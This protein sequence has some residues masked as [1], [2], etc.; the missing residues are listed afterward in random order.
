MIKLKRLLI[1]VK[2]KSFKDL[3]KTMPS[4]L[5]KRIYN[6][7]KIKQRKDYHPEGNVL[8]HTIYSVD[9]AL[10]TGD[11]DL[12]IAAMLHDIGK[13]KT[14]GIHPKKGHETHWGHEQV[15]AK[16]I[17]KYRNWIVDIGG[18]PSNVY[19]IVKNSGKIKS[20]H[21]MR[22][23]KQDKMKVQKGRFSKLS[24][25][26]KGIDVGGRSKK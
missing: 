24:K 4:Q 8:K 11:I 6:L 23:F 1:E 12:A 16:L 18:T 14:A 15:S 5:Q 19:Y 17:K 22:K 21:N 10:K 9:R 7:K 25:F 2:F 13:D 3:Y 20:F 26:G